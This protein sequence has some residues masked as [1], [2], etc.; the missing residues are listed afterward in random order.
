MSPR[1]EQGRSQRYPL[2]GLCPL[3]PDPHVR[4]DFFAGGCRKTLRFP[5]PRLGPGRA[6]QHRGPADLSCTGAGR[7]TGDGS[8]AR[9]LPPP[10]AGGTAQR[11]TAAARGC[12]R[13]YTLARG[14]HGGAHRDAPCKAPPRSGAQQRRQRPPQGRQRR[15]PAPA[16]P[17]SQLPEAA[18]ATD[19]DAVLP[20]A[21]EPSAAA[22]TGTPPPP[23]PTHRRDRQPREPTRRR[24]EPR[25]RSER[26]RP[27]LSG[28]PPAPDPAPPP[29][30][31]PPR[32]PRSPLPA[33]GASH[34][35]CRE[36]AP[37]CR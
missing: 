26:S 1:R 28:Q 13:R 35:G 25:E 6:R 16:A 31:R 10:A 3:S 5:S 2:R 23:V 22:G 12:A 9:V 15:N 33:A 19:R 11:G 29:R 8:G 20:I 27:P 4:T 37:S 18:G 32:C 7:G 24:T 17:R 36:A 34:G 21:A 14:V 30:H